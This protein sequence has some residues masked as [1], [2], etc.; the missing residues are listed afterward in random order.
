MI[1]SRLE[2]G[3]L[4]VK[5][6]WFQ[7]SHSIRHAQKTH[8]SSMV[9]QVSHSF[10]HAQKTHVLSKIDFKCRTQKAR[11][12]NTCWVRLP[13][14]SQS[15]RHAQKTHVKKDWLPSLALFSAR[16]ESL[17]SS[18]I[19]CKSCTFFGTHRNA[20]ASK[21]ASGLA[22]YSARTENAHVEWHWLRHSYSIQHAQSAHV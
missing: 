4:A 3:P 11:S 8:M 21:I 19:E 22:L 7:I 13:Q 9:D 1:I 12:K 15:I 5:Q 6:V 14:I 18:R 17:M 16:R 20:Y 10:R 2:L